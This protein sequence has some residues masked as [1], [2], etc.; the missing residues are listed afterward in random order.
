MTHAQQNSSLYKELKR[1]RKLI[2]KEKVSYGDLVFLQN[3]QVEVMEFFPDDPL[4][5]Q[6]AGIEEA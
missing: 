3:Y 2:E 4:L 5:W 1:I 6:W